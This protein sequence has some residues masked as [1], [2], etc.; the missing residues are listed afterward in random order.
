MTHLYIECNMGAA[1]DMIAAALL[2]YFVKR[3]GEQS[4]MRLKK[5]GYGMGKK[6]FERGNFVRAMYGEADDGKSTVAE[7]CC[8]IDDMTAEAIA[9]A[10][11]R[12]FEAGALDVYTMSANMKK[13]RL[14]VLLSCVCKMQDRDRMLQLIFKHT[15][16]LGVRENITNRFTMEREIESVQSPYGSLRLKHARGYGQMRSKVEYEDAAKLAREND[17]SL[18]ELLK[19][20]QI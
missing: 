17:I 19:S 18:D 12:L 7:L 8:N 3:F 11:E 16:T 1:G 15:T 9:Y 14:G 5:I 13:G 4:V 20:V 2:R 10:S 6:D